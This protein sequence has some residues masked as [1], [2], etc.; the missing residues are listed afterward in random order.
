MN[1]SRLVA[2]SATMA[3]TLPVATCTPNASSRIWAQRSTGTK[4]A[5]EKYA[6]SAHTLGP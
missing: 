6:T 2:V 5:A 3:A 4:C 1:G